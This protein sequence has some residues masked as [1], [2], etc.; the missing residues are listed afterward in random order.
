MAKYK[1]DKYYINLPTNEVIGDMAFSFVDQ[2]E[3][4]TTD[5]DELKQ[6]LFTYA[7]EEAA[8][9]DDADSMMTIYD[10]IES[11][12]KRVLYRLALTPLSLAA[13]S[14]HYDG[15]NQTLWR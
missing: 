2:D 12:S 4:E 10:I 1:L 7:P 14:E 9:I 11:D 6:S 3:T 15:I 13:A 8:D 5:F